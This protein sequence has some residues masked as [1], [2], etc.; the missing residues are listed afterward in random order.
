VIYQLI[1]LQVVT[2]LAI[3]LF[4]KKLLYTETRKETQ[5]LQGLNEQYVKKQEELQRK[6]DAAE[7]A[8]REKMSAAEEDIRKLRIK[9][10]EE[11]QRMRKDKA[12]QAK[13]EAEEIIK[14]ALG[15]KDKIREEIALQM[16]DNA[17]GLACRIFKEILSDEAGRIVHKEL[18]AEVISKIKQMEKF[19]F[20][21]KVKKAELIS[22]YPLDKREKNEITSSV[23]SKLG[24]KVSFD[25]KKDAGLIAG[26]IVKLDTL[27]IDGSLNSRLKRIEES[28]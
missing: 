17:P 16:R 2:F 13:D 12:D 5:R 24:Y 23:S 1:I 11:L 19:G 21:I 27:L 18:V 22:A 10:E 20:K 3:V 7:N 4:L 14:S 8:Y 9:T 26:V 28:L 6:I 25:E 15:T